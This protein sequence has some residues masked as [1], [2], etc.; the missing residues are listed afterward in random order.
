[1]VENFDNKASHKDLKLLYYLAPKALKMAFI[2]PCKNSV[3]ERRFFSGF[4]RD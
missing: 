3:E 1:M 4:T 2:C